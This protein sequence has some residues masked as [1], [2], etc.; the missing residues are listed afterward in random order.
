[1]K[2]LGKISSMKTNVDNV[3][4]ITYEHTAVL[5]L[6]RNPFIVVKKRLT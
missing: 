2:P 6:L 5:R 4:K 3:Q 1:M